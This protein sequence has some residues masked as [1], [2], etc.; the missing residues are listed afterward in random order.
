MRSLFRNFSLAACAVAAALLLCELGARL[1]LAPSQR[2]ARDMTRLDVGWASIKGLGTADPVLGYRLAPDRAVSEYRTNAL[3]YRAFAFSPAKPA[4]TFRIVCLGGSTTIGSNAGHNSY[5]YPEI[6]NDFFA[7]ALAGTGKRVEVVNAGVFGYHSWHSRIR[8]ARELDAL[9]PD[10]YCVMDGINDVLAAYNTR[11]DVIDAGKKKNQDLL[12]RLVNRSGGDANEAPAGP[13]G[14]LE[15]S[16]LFQAASRAGL[17]SLSALGL[18]DGILAARFEH[19]GYKDNLARL[20]AAS[21]E[22][23]I[24]VLLVRYPWIVRPDLG[25]GEARKRLPYALPVP[26]AGAYVF[27]RRAVR[28]ADEALSRETGARLAD[29]QPVFDDLTRDP[30]RIRDLYSDT[31]HLTRYGNLVLAWE[32]YKAL[33]TDPGLLTF[34]GPVK[35]PA[36]AA[37]PESFGYL[38]QWPQL[39]DKPDARW[40]LLAF[41]PQLAVERAENLVQTVEDGWLVTAPADPASP[42]RLVLRFLEE[43][44]DRTL[45]VLPRACSPDEAVAVTLLGPDGKETA[46]LAF[47]GDAPDRWTPALEPRAVTLPPGKLG[48]SRI[49]VGLRGKN[50]QIWSY[51]G[52]V[53]FPDHLLAGP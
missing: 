35:L 47:H 14:W 50:A 44:A 15:R 18:A 42:G 12:V 28:Q 10:M 27:G 5:A 11:L 52:R 17:A 39:R 19:F 34:L 36:V 32:V 43:P 40:R 4:D 48:D 33:I 51:G 9:S 22:K 24:E 16:A 25:P 26:L 53:F 20:I 8:A 31:M 23:G 3:G 2:D 38:A 41:A 29:P 46:L 49:V 37:F 21:R 7:R 13:A 6:L 1:L 45:D 30:A